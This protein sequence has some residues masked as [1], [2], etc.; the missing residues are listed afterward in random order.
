MN[1]HI[2]RVGAQPYTKWRV[3]RDILPK[4]S[5]WFCNDPRKQSWCEDCYRTRW[6]QNLEIYVYYDHS[7]VVCKSGCEP[8]NYRERYARRRKLQR[9]FA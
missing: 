7:K 6:A 2:Y 8:S 3:G 9:R 5:K 4:P 1:L